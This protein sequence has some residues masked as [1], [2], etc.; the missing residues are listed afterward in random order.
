[1]KAYK[2]LTERRGD[3]VIDNCG[4]CPNVHNY[5]GCT[6]KKCYEIMKNRLADLEDKIKSGELCD[7][8]ELV[9]EIL[10]KLYTELITEFIVSGKKQEY[11]TT[12]KVLTEVCPVK[13][14]KI[15]KHISEEYGIKLFG[16]SDELDGNDNDSK[17]YLM[18]YDS[19][20][21]DWTAIDI[22]NGRK[23]KRK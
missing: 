18:G 2:R 5:Q 22:F 16:N 17:P 13:V 3:L 8:K 7:C 21:G 11:S 9:S 20:V 4:N 12:R 23:L 6:D 1:M 10:S 14:K 15:C 19:G